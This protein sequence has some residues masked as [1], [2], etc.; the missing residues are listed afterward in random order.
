MIPLTKVTTETI[1]TRTTSAKKITQA[2]IDL[3][4]SEAETH[5]LKRLNLQLSK[6]KTLGKFSK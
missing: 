1:E 4:T 3:T 5:L 6:E 2:N